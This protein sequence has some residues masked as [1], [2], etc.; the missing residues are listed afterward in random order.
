MT[1]QSLPSSNPSRTRGLVRS[2]IV[3]M[4]AADLRR[5][6][7]SGQLAPGTPLRQEAL[8]E[9]LGVSRIPLREAI[10]LLSSEGLV[11][12]R[13]HRGA[14]VTPLSMEEVREFFD[15]RVQLEPW[16]LRL[17]VPHLTEVELKQAEALVD[18][19]D[20]AAADEWSRLNWRFHETLYRPAN[21]PFALNIVRTLHE[22]SERY[23]NHRTISVPQRIQARRE[24][25]ELV[26]LCRRGD[27]DAAAQALD[28]HIADTTSQ[29]IML[30]G[31]D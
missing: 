7:L 6:I 24:H 31:E 13:P 28:R 27:A 23:L 22:K 14:Y 17:A 16:L 3:E 11:D 5:R 12:L 30:K 19:M 8:A 1:D 2:T 9:E 29:V 26:A 15:L 25:M 20:D 21:R 4:V 10:R 18:I